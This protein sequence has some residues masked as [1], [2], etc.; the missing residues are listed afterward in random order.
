MLPEKCKECK[1]KKGRGCPSTRVI[2]GIGCIL[3]GLLILLICA[4]EWL[5]SLIIAMLLFGLGFYL[6]GFCRMR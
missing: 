2:V 3:L 1:C 6:I 4:P 5:I